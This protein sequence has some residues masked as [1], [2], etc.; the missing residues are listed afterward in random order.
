MRYDH[1][2]ARHEDTRNYAQEAQD[3][4]KGLSD[5]QLYSLYEIVV[6]KL[7]Y[8]NSPTRD[9]ELKAVQTAIKKVRDIDKDRLAG[10]VRGYRSS[11]AAEATPASGYNPLNRK[12]G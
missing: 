7:K 3:L 9:N 4:I 8:S 11:M 5:S 1:R 2:S 6:N 12:K 10:I